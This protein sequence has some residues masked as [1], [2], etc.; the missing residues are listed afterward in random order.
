MGTENIGNV[1]KNIMKDVMSDFLFE[2]VCEIVAGMI[3]NELNLRL[4]E[5]I[6]LDYNVNS[7]VM[8]YED[9]HV[10][11]DIFKEDGEVAAIL[12][13]SYGS[14]PAVEIDYY[15]KSVDSNVVVNDESIHTSSL[16]RAMQDI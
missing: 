13:G 10:T 11:V 4:S 8:D 12:T 2:P 7:E 1:A 5:N 3:H 14:V 15:D 16:N 9:I 6:T